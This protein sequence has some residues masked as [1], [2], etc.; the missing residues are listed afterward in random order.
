MLTEDQIQ[1]QLAA[2]AEERTGY[3]RG[4][5]GAQEAG[6]A[7]LE[8]DFQQ[9]LE[10]VDGRDAWLRSQ[11]NEQAEEPAATPAKRERGAGRQTRPRGRGRQTREKPAEQAPEEPAAEE[12]AATPATDPETP[13]E[14]DTV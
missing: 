12:P 3:E 5:L 4:L 7:E 11:S 1:N 13:G 10:A 9:R 14:G 2:V 8:A 6:D